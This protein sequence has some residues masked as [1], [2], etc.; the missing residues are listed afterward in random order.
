MTR[1]GLI[2]Q[3]KYYY[4]PLY[5]EFLVKIGAKARVSLGNKA[6]CHLP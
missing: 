2:F 6:F 3:M 1:D 5:R 4:N